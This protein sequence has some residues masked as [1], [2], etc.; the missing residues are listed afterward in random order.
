MRRLILISVPYL[1][2]LALFL[3][4]F[5]IVLKISLSEPTLVTDVLVEPNVHVKKG[6]P[7]FQFDR[8]IYEDKV[9]QLEAELAPADPMAAAGAN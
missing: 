4:P 3:I 9:R 6:Q 5:L 8:S 1:W 7:L 2:L